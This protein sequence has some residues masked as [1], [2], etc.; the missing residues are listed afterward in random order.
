MQ[1]KWIALTAVIV[2][3]ACLIGCTDRA[4]DLGNRNIRPNAVRQDA[5]GNRVIDKRF[6]NDQMNEMNRV[7]GRR[8][9]S[10]NLVG[11][12][13]NY[14][15]E[16]SQEMAEKIAA[17]DEVD[18]AYVML[19]DRN[20][21]I[22]V[23]LED[24]AANRTGRGMR[25]GMRTNDRAGTNNEVRVTDALKDRIANQVKSMKPSVENVFVSANPDF[26]GR[27]T[28]YWDDVRAGRPVQ[29]LIAEFNAMVDRIFPEEAGRNKNR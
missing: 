20:A 28:N 17:M 7:N 22:A 12:H 13:Q 25:A 4:G 9:N 23:T 10:N 11:R 21:Y 16:M 18:A 14:R 29:G 26:F 5:N 24:N 1:R 3:C 27:M 15:I 2:S 8:L 6:A 19:G